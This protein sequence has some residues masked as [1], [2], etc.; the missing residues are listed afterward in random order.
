MK[1]LASIVSFTKNFGAKSC[2]PNALNLTELAVTELTKSASKKL[3][4]IHFSFQFITAYC[5]D[6]GSLSL[7]NEVTFKKF[8]SV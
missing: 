5:K 4:N 6:F 2:L 3:T 1:Y 7:K 8:S